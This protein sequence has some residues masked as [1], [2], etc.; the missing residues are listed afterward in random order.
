[1]I[2]NSSVLRLV[3]LISGG[4]STMEALAKACKERE[5]RGK[6]AVVGVIASKPSALGIEK[7]KIL[8]IP[9]T[10]LPRKDYEE[11]SSGT[12]QW[13]KA[14][15]NAITAFGA[16]AVSQNGWVK[17]TPEI[18]IYRFKD[19]FNQ[20]PAP[21][22]PDHLD[23]NGD[24]LDFGGVGMFGLAPHAAVIAFQK[25]A[26]RRFPT[27]TTIHRVGLAYDH[28]EVVYRLDIPIAAGDTAEMLQQRVLP[29]EHQA[30]IRF[31]GLFA[32]TNGRVATLHRAAPLIASHEA[33]LLYQAKQ[34][35]IQR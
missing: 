30:Q 33:Y 23:S 11:G 17:Q 13:G 26:H 15:G 9:V 19:I 1:M 6:V 16:D 3:S 12:E 2:E 24:P 14:I 4:G 27:E 5:L 21:L 31:W 8:G 25:L 7:A 35:A 20:H 29:Y 32:R 28:G 34:L 22:D 18:V 10:V